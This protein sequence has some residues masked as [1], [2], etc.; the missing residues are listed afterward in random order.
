MIDIM[1]WNCRGLIGKWSEAKPMLMKHS[2]LIFCLQETHFLANDPYDFSLLNY[3]SYRAY[4]ALD[5]RQVSDVF[6][7]G[8]SQGI[9]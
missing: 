1:Q 2:A 7:D 8:F 4:S 9:F 3:S 6:S 5:V